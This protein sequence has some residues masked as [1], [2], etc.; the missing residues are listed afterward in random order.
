LLVPDHLKAKAPAML[1]L[2]Q[3]TSLGKAE[4]AGLGGS[5]NLHYAQELAERGYVALAPDYPNF[6]DYSMN[7]YAKGYA[8]AT[9]KGICNHMRAVELLASLAEVDPKRIGV[10]GHSLGGHN[11]LFVA[12]FDPRI[13][14][15]VTSC[16]FNSFFAYAGGDLT[17]WSHLGY[18]PR[19]ATCFD[20][21]PKQ[22]PFDFTEVLA[23]VAPRA[24]FISAPME[25]S[26]FPVTGVMDCVAAAKPVYRLLGAADKL[27][28]QYPSGGHDF[29]PK[30]RQEAYEWLDRA[31][32]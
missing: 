26:N 30:I 3:T 6:G 10:L 13:K 2:H 19:I 32:K 23:A 1:C 9:M 15:V 22:M 17:G 31:L 20:N 28:V 7:P 25:D 24:V 21:D 14:A 5:H 4:P 16:G 11:A 12:A 18:M 29:P 27:M 8:S